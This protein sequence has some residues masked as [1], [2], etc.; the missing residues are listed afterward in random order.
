MAVQ[1]LK[2]KLNGL[3]TSD[4]FSKPHPLAQLNSQEIDIARQA[5]TKAR[6]GYLLLFRGIFTE[7][8]AKTE[9]VPFLEAE[10]S[11]NLTEDTPRPPRL[12]R[13]QYDTIN[14]KG[15]HAYTESTVDL[16]S[17]KEIL[18]RVLEKSFE[19]PLTLLVYV[20]P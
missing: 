14:E 2:Q 5:I 17:G 4:K 1:S 9:L 16:N 3:T 15:D 13:V 20:G 11:G 7:E 19:P 8:P 12:A 18:H 10:H 6:T